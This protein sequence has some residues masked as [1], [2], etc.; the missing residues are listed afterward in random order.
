M[1]NRSLATAVRGF[2]RSLSDL[3]AF[4]MPHCDKLTVCSFAAA[5]PQRAEHSPWPDSPTPLSATVQDHSLRAKARSRVGENIVGHFTALYE[6]VFDPQNKYDDPRV[7]VRYKPQQ[8]K[9][10]VDAL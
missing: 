5:A 4:I 2:E 10:I 1:D 9:T 7:V 8:V 6:A 3:E